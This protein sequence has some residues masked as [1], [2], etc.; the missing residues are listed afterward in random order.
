MVSGIKA[1]DIEKGAGSVADNTKAVVVHVR[2]FLNRGEEFWNTYSEG[3]PALLDL[4]KRDSIP[5]LIKGIEGMQV[6]GKRELVVSPHLAY[7]ATGLPGKVPPNAVVRFE[8][9][10]LNVT[11]SGT[12]HPELYPPG[13]YLLVH[14]SGEQVRN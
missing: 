8:V 4:S 6:G 2:G 1:T 7:G 10:L 11:E 14:R 13:Q 9:E 3:K 12:F 5:G